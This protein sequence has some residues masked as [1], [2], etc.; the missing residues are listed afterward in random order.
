MRRSSRGVSYW[1]CSRASEG[2]VVAS[3]VLYS[4]QTLSECDHAIIRP[5]ELETVKAH[6]LTAALRICRSLSNARSHRH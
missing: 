5:E 1:I 4:R 2:K 6:E 3:N